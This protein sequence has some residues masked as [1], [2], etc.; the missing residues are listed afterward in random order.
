MTWLS[1]ILSNKVRGCAISGVLQR[2]GFGFGAGGS[3]DRDPF[4]AI[5]LAAAFGDPRRLAPAAAQIIELGPPHRATAHDLDR[6]DP[7]RGE[8]KDALDP[9]PPAAG[10]AAL[11]TP[12]PPD[13]R[14]P[15]APA[16]PAAG[17]NAGIRAARRRNFPPPMSRRS[18]PPPAAA[19]RRRRSARSPP[20]RH[21][22]GRNRRG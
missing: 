9:L 1:Q 15:P 3:R 11:L 20:V 12:P 8:R 19:A 6:A 7:R 4:A 22:T 17:C 21:P 16:I 14:A 18:R 5:V 2:L 10:G 13:P